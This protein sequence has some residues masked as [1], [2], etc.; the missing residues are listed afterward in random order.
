M[1]ENNATSILIYLH[2][3]TKLYKSFIILYFNAY[4]LTSKGKI[5]KKLKRYKLFNKRFHVPIYTNA[6]Y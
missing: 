4:F 2:R 3:R 1:Y 6:R 5:E